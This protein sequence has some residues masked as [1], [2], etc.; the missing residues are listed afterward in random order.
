VAR[1]LLKTWFRT[2]NPQHAPVAAALNE[3]GTWVNTFGSTQPIVTHPVPGGVKLRW[4]PWESPFCHPWRVWQPDPAMAHVSVQAGVVNTGQT[5]VTV[6]GL[7]AVD[8]AAGRKI[9]LSVK[10]YNDPA[11]PNDIALASG[12]GAWPA[13]SYSVDVLPDAGNPV[14]LP[15]AGWSITILPVAEI[16]GTTLNQYLYEDVLLEKGLTHT[17]AEVIGFRWNGTILEAIQAVVTYVRGIR[18]LIATPT[19]VQLF[20]T[21]DCP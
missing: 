21:G 18:T 17:T 2:D 8:A 20:D 15:K 9:W 5:L 11:T 3:L 7:T 1:T 10:Y 19:A 12:T 4:Q 13:S 6:T 14:T 16:V